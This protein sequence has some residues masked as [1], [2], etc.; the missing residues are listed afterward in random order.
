[1]SK[2]IIARGIVGSGKTR[3]LSSLAHADGAGLVVCCAA[4]FFTKGGG[5]YLDN[6]NPAR[7]GDAH[8]YCFGRFVKACNGAS[9]LGGENIIAVSN[10]NACLF[11]VSPYI[12]Y[13]Q[14]SG[15][16]IEI[17]E[18]SIPDATATDYF[19]FNTHG[20]PL[21]SVEGMLARWEKSLPFWPPVTRVE[22][23]RDVDKFGIVDESNEGSYTRMIPAI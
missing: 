7:L 8:Q 9:V 18:V 20:V 14:L 22:T 5:N 16:D 15:L 6:F 17:H 1:M 11:E 13:A 4:D 19:T 21:P 2:V 10:T 3:Y 12:M 23:L